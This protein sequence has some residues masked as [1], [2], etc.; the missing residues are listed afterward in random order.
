MRLHRTMPVYY[1]PKLGRD[2]ILG[3][4]YLGFFFRNTLWP[5]HPPTNCW[6]SN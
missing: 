5:H 2:T 6:L 3:Y 1:R 4:Y